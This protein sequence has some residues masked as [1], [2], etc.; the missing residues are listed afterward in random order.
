MKDTTCVF[1]ETFFFR[2]F[3]LLLRDVKNNT[4]CL[5][6]R[7]YARH[8]LRSFFADLYEWIKLDS[9]MQECVLLSSSLVDSCTLVNQN[10]IQRCKTG[11]PSLYQPLK[12]YTYDQVADMFV[13]WLQCKK[14]FVIFC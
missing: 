14:T 6:G 5:E 1:H 3:V 11:I 8:C 9:V 4:L 13:H 10:I 12:L 2:N 7:T